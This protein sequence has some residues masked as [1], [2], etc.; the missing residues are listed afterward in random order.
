MASSTEETGPSRL[1]A[2]WRSREYLV[3]TIGIPCMGFALLRLLVMILDRGSVFVPTYTPFVIGS[4]CRGVA[5]L[6]IIA[7][8]AGRP[9]SPAQYRRTL[10]PAAVLASVFSVATLVRV[11]WGG[12]WWYAACRG[13]AHVGIAWLYVCW[14]EVYANTRVRDVG[15]SVTASMIVSSVLAFAVALLPDAGAAVCAGIIPAVATWLFI[16][17]IESGAP[18]PPH[19]ATFVGRSGPALLG[20]YSRWLVALALFSA[21]MGVIHALSMSVP[22]GHAS[23]WLFGLYTAVSVALSAILLASVVRVR[24]GTFTLPVMWVLFVALTVGALGLSLVFPDLMPVALAVFGAVRYTALAFV[25]IKLADIAHHSHQPSYVIFAIGWAVVEI[26]M[27][28]GAS[29]QVSI[30]LYDGTEPSMPI[31]M[32]IGLLLTATLFVFGGSSFSDVRVP[33]D[34]GDPAGAGWGAG[35]GG[36]GGAGEGAGEGEGE[37]EPSAETILG[38]QYRQCQALRGRYG[39]T[40][41]ETEV[42]LL[43]AQGHTQQFCADALMVSLNTVRT[44]MKHVYAKLDIHTKDELLEALSREVG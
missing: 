38:I 28:L 11:A 5:P 29:L 27:V 14:G 15:V 31:A 41:R 7:L 37:G 42:V 21:V 3:D 1:P 36:G 24:E 33:A 13:L 8:V 44:H 18:H 20:E 23:G 32:L 43:V 9:L 19:R 10:V 39:L 16:R 25:N 2:A 4:L 30:E 35:A 17:Y 6:V 40:D 12:V 26:F 34:G 22:G